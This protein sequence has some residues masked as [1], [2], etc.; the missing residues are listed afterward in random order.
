VL[1]TQV[2]LHHACMLSA[3]ALRQHAFVT[4]LVGSY[5]M[6]AA[7]PLLSLGLTRVFDKAV[8]V[9]SSCNSILQTHRE[10]TNAFRAQQR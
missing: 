2:A 8:T 9:Y 5:G 4:V 6:H 3:H 10:N 1:Y 7:V